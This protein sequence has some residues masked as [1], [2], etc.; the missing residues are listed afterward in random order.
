ML[1][2]AEMLALAV[3]LRS[4]LRPSRADVVA[5]ADALIAAAVPAPSGRDPATIEAAA[6]VVEDAMVEFDIDIR[7]QEFP[8]II[9][10]IRALAAPARS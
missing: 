10:R 6:E 5:A 3:R 2:E 1:T 9:K 7:N 4:N 8:E